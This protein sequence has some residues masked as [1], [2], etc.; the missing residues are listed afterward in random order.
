[1]ESDVLD[2]QYAVTPLKRFGDPEEMAD[3]IAFL[4]SEESSYIT[5]ATVIASGGRILHP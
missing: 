1:L 5:G 2:R 3:V 4:L